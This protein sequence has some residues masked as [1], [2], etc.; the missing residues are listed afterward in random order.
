M[1]NQNLLKSYNTWN[2]EDL[3]SSEYMEK[4]RTYEVDVDNKE[5]ATIYIFSDGSII[6]H[7]D[8]QEPKLYNSLNIYLKDILNTVYSNVVEMAEESDL[9]RINYVM[10]CLR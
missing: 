4:Q 3:L 5:L 2:K 8:D 6:V 1:Y 7:E 10:E 9:E